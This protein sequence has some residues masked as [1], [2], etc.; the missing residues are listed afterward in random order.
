[1]FISIKII[2]SNIRMTPDLLLLIMK[3][4]F[5]FLTKQGGK[6]YRAFHFSK[7]SLQTS[8]SHRKTAS[9]IDRVNGPLPDGFSN[10]RASQNTEE[11]ESVNYT[12]FPLNSTSGLKEWQF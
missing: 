10:E 7:G 8:N 11:N 9:K 12:F 1:M 3:V 2:I 5:H 6:P 4:F